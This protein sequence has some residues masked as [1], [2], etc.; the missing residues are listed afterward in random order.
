LQLRNRCLWEE[1]DETAAKAVPA[2]QKATTSSAKRTRTVK[3][4]EWIEM[5][6]L[7]VSWILFK[8]F[9]LKLP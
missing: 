7:A 5:A 8:S 6:Q 1:A 2:D 4:L 9:L 3:K